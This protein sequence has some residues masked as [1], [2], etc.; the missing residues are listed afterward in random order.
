LAPTAAALG[1]SPKVLTLVNQGRW[2]DV[3]SALEASTKDSKSPTREQAWLAFTYMFRNH[4][5][6][7]KALSEQ[8]KSAAAD[9]VNATIIQSFELLCEKKPAEAE[10]SLQSIP[11]SAMSDAFVNFAFAASA[12]KQGK[13]AA[14]ITYSQRATELAPDFAWGFR[15]SGFLQRNWLKDNAAAEKN[16]AKAFQIEPLLTD[17]GNVLIDLRLSHNDFDGAIDWRRFTRS[18]GD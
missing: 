2:K 17:A 18:N 11:A 12:A 6:P 9:N 7:L 13:A 1:L 10:K 3:E 16:Y 8:T 4:C 14:A 15:T 5:E